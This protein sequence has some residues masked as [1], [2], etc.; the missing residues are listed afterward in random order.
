MEN[1]KRQIYDSVFYKIRLSFSVEI[2]DNIEHK[3]WKKLHTSL[4]SDVD[5]TLRDNIKYKIYTLEEL[6]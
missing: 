5:N 3:S 6:Y 4:K 1:I 2:S